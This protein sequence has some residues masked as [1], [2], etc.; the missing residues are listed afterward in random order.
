MNRPTPQL[1][2]ETMSVASL[3]TDPPEPAAADHGEVFTRRWVVDLIL[4]L[5]GYTAE[6]DLASFTAVEP[7]CG[8][9]AFLVPMIERLA[10]SCE[11]HG[12]DLRV[13]GGAI[14][15]YDLLASNVEASR[16]GVAQVLRAHGLPFPAAQQLA[17]RW[18]V[19]ADFLLRG[20]CGPT[21]DFVLGNPPYIR[22]ENVP[23]ARST[24][25]RDVCVTMRGR[26]DV[27]VGFI[28]RGLRLLRDGGVLGFIVADRWMRNQYGAEL[29]AM[30][31]DS[32]AVDSLIQMHDV[33]AFEDRVSAYP[34][35]VVI[36][37]GQQGASVIA[38]ATAAFEQRDASRLCDWVR[39]GTGARLR[40]NGLEA[41]R[42]AG[43]FEGSSSWPAGTP[44]ELALVADL[45]ARFPSLEDRRT[46]TRVGIGVATGADSL[47]L[48]DDPDL[49]EPDRLLPL[50]MAGDTTGGTVSWSGTYL[51]SPWR[52]GQLVDLADYPR[53]RTY[54]AA[55]DKAIRARHVA[56]RNAKSWYR[57]IDR[58]EPGLL[59]RSKL[60][61][62][63]LKASIHPVL[64]DGRRYPH[65]NLYFVTSDAWD[66]DVLGGL[67]LSDV[68]NLF[69]GAYCVKMRGGCYRFQ[70]QYLRRIRVPRPE[71]LRAGD[72]R[73]LAQA[74]I[75]R[76]V[77]AATEIA[78]RLYEIDELPASCRTLITTSA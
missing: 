16:R 71:A 31:S 12:Q 50:V 75:G 36:R 60:L 21:A 38:D 35:V 14:Q 28:E 61:L 48:T 18:V 59:E 23:P 5:A 27:F 47:Y 6:R 62:P 26:S 45:E 40:T 39:S 76:D 77:E 44:D 22:L 17:E 51:V 10:S 74:F 58:V 15:A 2:F 25:Y 41:A 63:D 57:T 46:S 53:L 19:Q 56:R 9:G 24:A 4:D 65:H 11:A 52:D 73:A 1:S 43:W 34:A 68:A 33:D 32:F 49:V 66:L 42:L 64:E 13:A 8:A 30:I 55:H 67:L 20:E 70:A 54:L 72:K 3:L 37:C 7:A 78:C 69:V 29:R